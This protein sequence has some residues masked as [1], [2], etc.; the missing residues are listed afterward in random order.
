MFKGR[1]GSANTTV[2]VG[3]HIRVPLGSRTC[4]FT[5]PSIPPDP[6]SIPLDFHRSFPP[7]HPSRITTTTYAIA[8]SGQL[9]TVGWS[10][11]PT[12]PLFGLLCEIIYVFEHISTI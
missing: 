10:E 8:T 6:H 3:F 2:H 11:Q 4:P 5:I 12:V 7:T 1:V 9:T